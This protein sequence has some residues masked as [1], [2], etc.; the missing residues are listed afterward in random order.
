MVH[1]QVKIYISFNILS[2]IKIEYFYLQYVGIIVT[3]LFRMFELVT[4]AIFSFLHRNAE[5]EKVQLPAISNPLLLK[6]GSSL[7]H[8]IRTQQ[9]ITKISLYFGNFALTLFLFLTSS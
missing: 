9:V 4:D 7:A 2:K 3:F 8:K 1:W 6:S 5:K